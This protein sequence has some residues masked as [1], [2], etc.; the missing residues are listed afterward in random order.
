MIVPSS[1][2]YLEYMEL[3]LFVNALELVLLEQKPPIIWCTRQKEGIVMIIWNKLD[4]SLLFQCQV[5]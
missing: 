4:A 2:R 3:Y 5:D 1:S